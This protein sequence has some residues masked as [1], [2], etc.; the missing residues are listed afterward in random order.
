MSY[1][2]ADSSTAIALTVP[3]SHSSRAEFQKNCIEWIN[4]STF[5]AR[6][7][8][9][10]IFDKYEDR[11]KYASVDIRLGLE[12]ELPAGELGDCRLIVALQWILQAGR[13]IHDDMMK[14]NTNRWNVDRWKLWAARL[15][16]IEEGDLPEEKLR[17]LV[18]RTSEIMRAIESGVYT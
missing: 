8:G 7:T 1:Y 6:C 14:Q 18:Q 9:A 17:L 3:G 11:Y 12:E 5:L 16:E 4:L 2:S 10:A 13:G 15:K